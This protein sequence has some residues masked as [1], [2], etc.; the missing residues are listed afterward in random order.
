MMQG[1]NLEKF[2]INVLMLTFFTLEMTDRQIE[3]ARQA[4][5]QVTT[6]DY[7]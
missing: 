2:V 7:E 1:S 6:S 4:R 3:K 5:L